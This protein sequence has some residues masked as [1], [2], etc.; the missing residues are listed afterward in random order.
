M[1][2]QRCFDA[3]GE[4]L[5]SILGAAGLVAGVH[6]IDEDA[7]QIRIQLG[8]QLNVR[9]HLI[10]GPRAL[11]G[12]DVANDLSARVLQSLLRVFAAAALV[13][14][15]TAF[16]RAEDYPARPVRFIVAFAP[17]GTV[18]F[19]ARMIADK[20]RSNLVAGEHRHI[21]VSPAFPKY[22]SADSPTSRQWVKP[23]RFGQTCGIQMERR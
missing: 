22:V 14:V 6:L 3:G 5:G 10:Q 13:I 21:V 19:T 11:A 20:M 18:D 7:I 1:R 4:L 15:T 2:A 16:G 23:A 8:I 9:L 12:V 17:G